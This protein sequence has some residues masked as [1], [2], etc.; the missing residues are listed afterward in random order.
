MAFAVKSIRSCGATHQLGS[1]NTPNADVWS[2]GGG[3]L[4]RAGLRQE[5]RR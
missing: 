5:V 2:P 1:Q 4:L 3:A